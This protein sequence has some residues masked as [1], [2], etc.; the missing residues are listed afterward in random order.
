MIAWLPSIPYAAPDIG[1]YWDPVTSTINW[2]EEVRCSLF[3]SGS[4]P[5]TGAFAGLL[6]DSIRGRDSEHTDEFTIYLPG[7]RWHPIV[8]KA[9]S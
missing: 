7:L 4:P 9:R 1:G 2:C 5:L 8:Q 3:P 6:R